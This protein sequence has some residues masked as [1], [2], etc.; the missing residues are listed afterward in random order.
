MAVRS[1]Q[2][3]ALVCS[4]FLDCAAHAVLAEGSRSYI[5][6]GSTGVRVIPPDGYRL[7][8]TIGDSASLSFYLPIEPNGAHNLCGPVLRIGE[9]RHSSGLDATYMLSEMAIEFESAGREAT[10]RI[11]V[12]PHSRRLGELQAIELIGSTELVADLSG[13]G[14]V[15]ITCVNHQLIVAHGDRFYSCELRDS[16][17]Q[18]AKHLESLERFC[19]SIVFTDGDDN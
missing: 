7:A 12:G 4:L 11:A 9:L 19:G 14:A 6:V 2:V 8:S 15:P 18:Y 3:S 10:P 5:E 1:I 16:M 13:G 17:E